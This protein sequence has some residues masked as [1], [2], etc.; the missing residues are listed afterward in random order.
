M[1]AYIADDVRYLVEIGRQVKAACVQADILEEVELD[2]ARMADEAASRP[3]MGHERGPK[4]SKN[5]LSAAQAA[6]ADAL[7]AALHCKR[8]EW[9]EKDNVPMGRMLSNAAGGAFVR[10]HGPEVMEL[11]KELTEKS[12]RGEIAPIVETAK[13]DSRTRKRED[14]LKAWRSEKAK[15]RKVTGSVVLSNLLVEDLAASEPLTM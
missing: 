11:I 10:E 3:D 2:C 7:G 4:I 12:A 1:R 8:L 13:K 9:A 5:G 15:E 6:L 14:R